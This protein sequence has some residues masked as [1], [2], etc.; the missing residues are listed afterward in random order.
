METGFQITALLKS[1]LARDASGHSA[2]GERED[3]LFGDL[4]QA[5]ETARCAAITLR[6]ARSA[7]IF[8]SRPFMSGDL[9]QR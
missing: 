4:P 6:S 7:S 9:T 2:A 5:I 8:C 3:V 1:H